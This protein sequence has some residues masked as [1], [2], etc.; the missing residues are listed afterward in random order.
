[1][2]DNGLDRKQRR[3][4]ERV[5]RRQRH[6]LRRECR[7]RGL[8]GEELERIFTATATARLEE[9][10]AMSDGELPER[11]FQQH[12]SYALHDAKK[13]A[14]AT[15]QPDESLPYAP[16]GCDG[17]MLEDV[18][19]A[20]DS[21]VVLLERHAYRT[22][23]SPN[24]RR[25][26]SD[27]NAPVHRWKGADVRIVETPWPDYSGSSTLV[28]TEHASRLGGLFE[29]LWHLAEPAIDF[30]SKYE[31]YGRIA[32]AANAWLKEHPDT[33]RHDLV[34][35]AAYEARAVLEDWQSRVAE[36]HESRRN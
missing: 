5:E 7:Q 8:P 17:A 20:V 36:M 28:V 21:L 3:M 1:M 33:D 35:V 10:V 25:A 11:V 30:R 32:D 15:V 29:Q 31:F 24:L 6:A 9:I 23:F 27:E 26:S 13:A 22:L 19:L 4:F 12:V 18:L 2:T 14:L 16:P 34:L